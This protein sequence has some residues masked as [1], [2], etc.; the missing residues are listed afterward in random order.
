MSDNSIV[1]K[2]NVAHR[3]DI[4]TTHDCIE[5]AIRDGKLDL[6]FSA[7]P[8]PTEA[9]LLDLINTYPPKKILERLDKYVIKQGEAKKEAA[10]IT[11][12]HMQKIANANKLNLPSQSLFM[13][14]PTGCGKT[15]IWRAIQKI[16]PDIKIKIVD[17]SRITPEGWKGQYKVNDIIAEFE[18]ANYTGILVVDEFDKVVAGNKTRPEDILYSNTIQSAFLKILEG[19][20]VSIVSENSPCSSFDEVSTENLTVVFLGAFSNLRT[21]KRNSSKSIGFMESVEATNKPL[22]TDD[23]IK[24]GVMPELA[25]RITSIVELSPL[26]R[27][28]YNSIISSPYGEVRELVLLLNDLRV[29]KTD[30][31]LPKSII[32]SAIEDAIKLNTGARGAVKGVERYLMGQLMDVDPE[33]I[34]AS[35]YNR[36]VDAYMTQE[37]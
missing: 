36:L 11:Y 28:D 22:C 2:L 20:T 17:G 35:S 18:D 10:L 30:E 6:E 23:L 4:N 34:K 37:E 16:I 29:Q 19:D 25:G 7:L 15:E 32:D 27:E 31:V 14:G 9:T 5:R 33:D 1:D 12:Y 26:D 13:V 3:I 24:Y 8:G 21:E